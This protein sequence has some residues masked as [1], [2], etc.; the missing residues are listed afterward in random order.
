MNCFIISQIQCQCVRGLCCGICAV[1]QDQK[2]IFDRFRVSNELKSR[3][4]TRKVRLISRRCGNIGRGCQFVKN[5]FHSA[6]INLCFN[7]ALSTSRPPSQTSIAPFITEKVSLRRPASESGARNGFDM[8]LRLVSSIR[9]LIPLRRRHST[10]S[11]VFDTSIY[12]LAVNFHMNA[13]A[14]NANRQRNIFLMS[15][16]T[17]PCRQSAREKNCKQNNFHSGDK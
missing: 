1:W 17:R 3:L 9:F 14:G 11:P 5:A 13:F 4:M 8:N 12:K 6:V 15:E 10:L 7:V 2:C 16:M